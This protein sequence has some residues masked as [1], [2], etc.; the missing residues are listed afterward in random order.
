MLNKWNDAYTV[1]GLIGIV[2]ALKIFKYLA[3]S[4]KL[5]A[6]WL[7]LSAA[8]SELLAFLVGYAPSPSTPPSLCCPRAGVHWCGSVRVLARDPTT[9]W[10]WRSCT[11]TAEALT[12]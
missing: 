8:M 4:K 5:N 7:T 1:A 2:A 6:L 9:A 3:L 12:F 11:Q 10:R